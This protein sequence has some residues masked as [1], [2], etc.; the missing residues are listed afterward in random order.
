M[1]F[2]EHIDLPAWIVVLSSAVFYWAGY[3]SGKEDERI[4]NA[5]DKDGNF[6]ETEKHEE[7]L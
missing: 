7:G 4:E 2:T 6:I 3:Q 1:I 5:R